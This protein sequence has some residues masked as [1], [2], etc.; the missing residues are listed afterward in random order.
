M[1]HTPEQTDR[2]VVRLRGQSTASVRQVLT[3]ARRAASERLAE[4]CE[5][6]LR[7]RGSFE[8]TE[9]DAAGA[10]VAEERTAD[11]SMEEVI[12]LAFKH[13]PAKPE[14]VLILRWIS[15]N[16]GTTF[17]ATA[18][19]YGRKDLGLVIGHLVYYR[20][21]Y[22]RRFLTGPIQSDVLLERTK[23]PEGVRYTLRSEAAVA[24]G[25]LG[26]I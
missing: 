6:E 9:A 22:F 16:P 13:I 17:S 10:L 20:F 14:E 1:A 4:A 12:G 3:N 18:Q 5:E 19:A 15:A 24:F 21:G 11:K 26:T 25:A 23:S 8:M 2:A 7:I